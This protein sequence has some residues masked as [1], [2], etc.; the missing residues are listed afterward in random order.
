MEGFTVKEQVFRGGRVVGL[1]LFCFSAFFCHVDADV[2]P[3]DAK[4]F[5]DFPVLPMFVISI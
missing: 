3:T 1:A 4:L 5:S 2:N